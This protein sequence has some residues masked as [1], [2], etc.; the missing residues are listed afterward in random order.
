MGGQREFSIRIPPRVE[1]GIQV[2]LSLE[3]IGLKD[4][5]LHVAVFIDPD[6]EKLH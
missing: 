6:L 1:H 2:R 4:A 3:D 5:Y